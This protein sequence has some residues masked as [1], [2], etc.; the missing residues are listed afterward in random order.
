MKGKNN[1]IAIWILSKFHNKTSVDKIVDKII[2]IY[3]DDNFISKNKYA[4]I[5]KN[6]AI[7]DSKIRKLLSNND[8]ITRDVILNFVSEFIEEN[9]EKLK[10]IE[11]D[12]C[13]KKCLELELQSVIKYKDSDMNSC[14]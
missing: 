8:N 7:K 9:Q 6:M 3:G 10:K 11:S 1:T 2:K 4:W 5:L 12:P 14:G 13:Y